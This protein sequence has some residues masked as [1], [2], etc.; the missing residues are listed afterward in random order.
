MRVVVLGAALLAIGVVVFLVVLPGTREPS[1]GLETLRTYLFEEHDTPGGGVRLLPTP[2][3]DPDDPLA[4]ELLRRAVL[5]PQHRSRQL[6]FGL[7]RD[8]DWPWLVPAVGEA[9]LQTEGGLALRDVP[10]DLAWDPGMRP[11]FERGL[12]SSDPRVLLDALEGVGQMRLAGVVGRIVPMM[13]SEVEAIQRAAGQALA[14][15]GTAEAYAP[16]VDGYFAWNDFAPLDRPL[17]EHISSAEPAAIDLVLARYT[18]AGERSFERHHALRLLRATQSRVALERLRDEGLGSDWSR[19]HYFA[20]LAMVDLGDVSGLR[21]LQR[22]PDSPHRAPAAWGLA[23]L[24]EEDEDVVALLKAEVEREVRAGTSQ[25]FATPGGDHGLVI[26]WGQS[27]ECHLE[28]IAAVRTETDLF[29]WLEGLLDL[30][31]ERAGEIIHRRILEALAIRSPA[32]A[33]VRVRAFLATLD[34]DDPAR[35]RA[36]DGLRLLQPPPEH[37]V[38][39]ASWTEAQHL[40]YRQRL[41]LH[42][43]RGGPGLSFEEAEALA[44][45][46]VRES[47]EG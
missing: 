5:E 20:Y 33:E 3:F 29:A 24:G 34:P 42:R 26:P 46:A 9:M 41:M 39:M 38:E 40:R 11:Y 44:F 27:A 2:A 36:E 7:A 18:E 15:I 31:V 23:V 19:A 6:A 25:V 12:R 43:R 1:S 10:E 17:F 35:L 13:S 14:R 30:P 32:R 47:G 45:A 22:D 37:A 28:T 8:Q 16:L 4:R 21:R